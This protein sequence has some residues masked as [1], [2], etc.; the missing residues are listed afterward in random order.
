MSYKDILEHNYTV[1][2]NIGV[3]YPKEFWMAFPFEGRLL[4]S[5]LQESSSIE[6]NIHK[7]KIK[8]I[9]VFL[10]D[11]ELAFVALKNAGATDV[12]FQYKNIL[13]WK[14]F[15]CVFS[16]KSKLKNITTIQEQVQKSLYKMQEERQLK[17]INA[18]W[19]NKKI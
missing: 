17:E 5:H 13:Y 11:N 18:Y 19:V 8:K 14:D 2:I 7:L 1:G 4:N 9:D 6:E 12:I 16:K 15:Y 3:I 10:A